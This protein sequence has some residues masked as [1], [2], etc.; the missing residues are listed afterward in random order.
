MALGG[1]TLGSHDKLRSKKPVVGECF[2]FL[3]PFFE[4]KCKY[5]LGVAPHLRIPQG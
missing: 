4:S 3:D 5:I 1:G 2:E